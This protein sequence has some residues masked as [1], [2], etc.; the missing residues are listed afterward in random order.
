[1][2]VEQPKCDVD[3]CSAEKIRAASLI[4]EF[5]KPP[6]SL[7]QVINYP[8]Y[9]NPEGALDVV[10]VKNQ[11]GWYQKNNMINYGTSI[12]DVVDRTYIKPLN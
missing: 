4:A 3:K 11:I 5:I 7:E 1:M 10:S 8:V 9:I 12:E 2:F 6:I